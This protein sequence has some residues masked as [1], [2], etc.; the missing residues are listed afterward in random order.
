MINFIFLFFFSSRRRQTGCALVTG[1]QTCALPIYTAFKAAVGAAQRFIEH[2]GE[3]VAR[4]KSRRGHRCFFLT[5]FVSGQAVGSAGLVA[6]P[7]RLPDARR[8]ILRTRGRV[9]RGQSKK[10]ATSADRKSV[11]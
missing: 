2:R 1:V 6:E 9:K 10:G 5:S 8:D 3:I 7:S 11:V 4:R